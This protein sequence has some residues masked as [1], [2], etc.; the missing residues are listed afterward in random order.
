MLIWP[1]QMIK[2]TAKQW[3]F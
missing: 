2:L 3:F 1:N